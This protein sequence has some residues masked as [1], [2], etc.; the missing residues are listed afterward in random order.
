MAPHWARTVR[1]LVLLFT[2]IAFLVTVLSKPTS[3]PKA[4]P[5]HRCAGADHLSGRRRNLSVHHASQRRSTVVFCGH[6]GG[7]CLPP[8]FSRSPSPIHPE[9]E[10][11]LHVAGARCDGYR[12]LRVTSPA[13]AN[14]IAA[15]LLR[16]RDST[17]TAPHIYFDWTE[18]DPVLNLLRYLIFGVGEVAP[19]TREI[20]RRAEP[21]ADLRPIVHVA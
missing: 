17:G 20:L 14:A 4:V 5:S 18:G 3:T 8:S 21:A 15:L 19:V 9:F 2:A 6:S 11:E 10:T 12:V 1:P 7:V 16:I 13:V